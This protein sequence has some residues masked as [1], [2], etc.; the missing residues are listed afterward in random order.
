M[1]NN[2][3]ARVGHANSVNQDLVSDEVVDQEYITQ[4]V[5]EEATYERGVNP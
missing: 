3:G 5:R 4:L 1:S 2:Y